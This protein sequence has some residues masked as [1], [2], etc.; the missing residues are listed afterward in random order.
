MKRFALSAFLVLVM[1]ALGP[2]GMEG[3]ARSM[4]GLPAFAPPGTTQQIAVLWEA[5]RRRVG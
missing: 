5:L 1:A 2:H 3:V 4:A